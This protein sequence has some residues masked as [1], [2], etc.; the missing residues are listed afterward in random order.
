MDSLTRRALLHLLSK[1]DDYDSHVLHKEVLESN[2]CSTCGSS[3]THALGMCNPCYQRHKRLEQKN[4]VKPKDLTTLEKLSGGKKLWG[5][6]N[7]D[8][9]ND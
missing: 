2:V 4:P 5:G 6:E 9:D 7:E 8:T 1:Q 3:K